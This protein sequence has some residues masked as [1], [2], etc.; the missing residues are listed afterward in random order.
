MVLAASPRCVAP[1]VMADLTFFMRMVM[2]AIVVTGLSLLMGYSGQASL[3]QGA[4]VAAGALTVAVGTTGSGCRPCSRCWPRRW[5]RR[6][7][8]RWSAYRCCGCTVTTS[9]SAPSPCC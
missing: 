9:P 7:S 8:R 1:L 5:W 6:R 2:A 4:F 3:G